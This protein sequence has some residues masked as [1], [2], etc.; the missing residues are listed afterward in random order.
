ME[1]YLRGTFDTLRFQ[2]AVQVAAQEA[3]FVVEHC[4][5]TE[6]EPL[7]AL[8]RV[9]L[10][11]KA[12]LFVS[13]GVHGDEPA[14]PLTILRMLKQDSLPHD[15]T[16]TVFP[17]LNPRGMAANKR[18]NADGLDINRDYRR[19]AS[20][21]ARC[22]RDWLERPRRRFDL[23]IHLHEDWEAR[24]YYLYELNPEREQSIAPD[25]L[26]AVEP[27]IG[28][29]PAGLIDGHPASRGLI[30]PQDTGPRMRGDDYPEALYM[31]DR[32]T[33]HTYTFEAP[34]N[35]DLTLR[36]A[37]HEAALLA[38]ADSLRNHGHWFDI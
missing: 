24:G 8:R 13:T 38:A 21:E 25:V 20:V 17:L 3:G 12:N 37:A 9:C 23:C 10:T 19:F 28:I 26:A 35:M 4:Y 34:S 30:R 2:R 32:Y 33:R 22:Q 36:I 29:E 27:V 11:P 31:L 5:G 14:G 15:M 16:L 18:E 1:G 7:L 6:P